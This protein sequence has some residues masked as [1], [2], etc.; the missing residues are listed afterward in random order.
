MSAPHGARALVVGSGV[1]GLVAARRLVDGGVAV[2]LLDERPAAGGRVATRT[3]GEATADAG[4]QFFTARRAPFVGL[5]A[6][7]RYAQVPIRVWSHGWVQGRSAADGP[8]AAAFADDVNPRYSVQGGLATLVSHLAA[9]LDVRSGVR[10]RSVGG[11]RAGVTVDDDAA[12]VWEADAVVVTPPLP[13]ARDLLDAGGLA[14][15]ERLRAIV[16]A[17][18]VAVLVALDRPPVVPTPGGVQ[19][20]EGPVAWLADNVAKGASEQPAVTIHASPDWSAAHAEEPDEAIAEA[21]LGEVRTWLGAAQPVGVHVERWPNARPT[22]QLDEPCLVVPGTD[23]RVVLA[24]D[25][26]VGALVGPTLEGA[27]LSGLAAADALL[28]RLG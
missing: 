27:A 8:A 21:L 14:V 10:A 12:T 20:S 17:P 9:G 4:A 15:P 2:T 28:A 26:F 23:D 18:C 3:V 11:T 6:A 25:A 16:Y 22:T 5:L 13:L 7:W 24:G 1:C 19:F